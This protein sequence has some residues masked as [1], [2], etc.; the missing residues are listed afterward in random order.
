MLI[1]IEFPNNYPYFRP[2][3]ILK[4]YSLPRHQH[5]SGKNLCLI[6]RPTQYWQVVSIGEFLET[7]L[8]L[9]LAKGEIKDQTEIALDPEEQAEPISENYINQ[10]KLSVISDRPSFFSYPLPEEQEGLEVL[11]HGFVDL[12]YPDNSN[13]IDLLIDP[14]KLEESLE[15]NLSFI[16]KRWLDSESVL[17]DGAFPF[18][19]K[20][21]HTKKTK[22]Y[23]LNRFPS[24]IDDRSGFK[25]FYAELKNKDIPLPKN[26]KIKTKDIELEYLTCL[27]FPEE[28]A[29]GEMGWGWMFLSQGKLKSNGR[30]SLQQIQLNIPIQSIAKE[31]VQLR[32]PESSGFQ[33]KTISVVGLGTLGALSALEMAKNG[34]KKLIL[35][36]F[37]NVDTT[38]NVRWPLGY[39][40]VG[41]QKTVALKNFINKNFPK[42]EVE[43][44]I[45]R[46]GS[47]QDAFRNENQKIE[48]FLNTD[49]IYD[50]SAE[51]GVNHF[52]SHL[53]RKK[54]V[55]YFVI[56]GRRGG[57]GGV[58]ARVLPVGKKGCW[59][60]LQHALFD[61][62]ITPPP[63]DS[64]GGIQAKGCGDI[65]FTG[66]SFDM[67]N[68]SLAGVKLLAQTLKGVKA[69]Y[70]VG[71]LS[72]V[73]ENENPILP[74]WDSYELN[75]HP[76]CP[77]CH[78][79]DLDKE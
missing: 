69:G 10:P 72:M 43:I 47:L 64:K 39:E 14:E 77:Y 49:L 27:I 46:I 40:Y 16:A 30:S 6:P 22:W 52:L 78:E 53:C 5:P 4:N 50:S 65:T 15:K 25:E 21:H 41:Q 70:D 7:R 28:I 31:D 35:M 51:E 37:D 66:S 18:Q 75:I 62:T 34:V 9:V 57:W 45:H 8:P 67:Y 55:P 73:D 23:L 2:E 76:N 48:K 63:D 74:K 3:V 54:G 32:I 19:H 56:E 44:L 79:R 20:N 13:T 38:S 12:S 60:C 17:I 36:D 42:V 68:I 59:M 71:V 61:K 11:K 29:K 58:I 26:L 1:E 33:E 24:F